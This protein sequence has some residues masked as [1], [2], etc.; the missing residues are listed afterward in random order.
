MISEA[1]CERMGG[2]SGM[3]RHWRF[4]AKGTPQGLKVYRV[5]EAE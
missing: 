5:G 3:S 1:V 2:T 4:R